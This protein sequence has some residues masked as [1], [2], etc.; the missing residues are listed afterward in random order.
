MA[1]AE[2]YNIFTETFEELDK[3]NTG[4]ARTGDLN[5]IKKEETT[6]PT[7]LMWLAVF[8]FVAIF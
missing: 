6:T 3:Q 8:V 7:T 1:E 2:F 5:D 4:Y